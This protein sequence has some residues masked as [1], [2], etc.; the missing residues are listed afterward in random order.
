LSRTAQRRSQIGVGLGEDRF[1]REKL[2]FHER[3][4]RGFLELA[5][6]EPDRFRI[7]NAAESAQAV[8]E[9]IKKIIDGLL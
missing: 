8:A 3:V 5:R 6:A 1:E 7:I 9:A 2:E 4:R